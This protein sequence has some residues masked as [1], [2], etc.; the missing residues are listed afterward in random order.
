MSVDTL[1]PALARLGLEAPEALLRPTAPGV[2]GAAILQALQAAMLAQLTP[3]AAVSTAQRQQVLLAAGR[4]LLA[5]PE[6]LRSALHL[7][8]QA[9]RD[10]ALT[11]PFVNLRI[12]ALE[13][14]KDRGGL[15]RT[16]NR[17]IAA[18]ALPEPVAQLVA[19]AAERHDIRQLLALPGALHATGWGPWVDDLPAQLDALAQ[20]VPSPAVSEAAIEH[21]FR[22]SRAGTRSY[23]DYRARLLHGVNLGRYLFYLRN[24]TS[25]LGAAQEGAQSAPEDQR[26]MRRWHSEI[27]ALVRLPDASLLQQAEAQGRTLLVLGSH[28][29]A[30]ALLGRSME[31]CSLP[32]SS[33]TQNVSADREGSFNISTLAPDATLRFA[34][35]IKMARRSPRLVFMFPDGAVGDTAVVE[36]QGRKLHIGRG[37]ASLAWFTRALPF[38]TR[39]VIEDGAIVLRL[40]PGPAVEEGE[41]MERYEKRLNA[42]YADCLREILAGPPENIGELVNKFNPPK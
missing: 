16:L 24:R 28:G 29:G 33:I 18:R 35:L 3:G 13:R 25:A 12:V 15:I 27:G 10:S 42:F 5:R 26:I 17:I 7:A 23:D 41:E 2:D 37:G 4:R 22:H 34:K 14:L 39:T 6:T 32:R 1:P 40:V 19:G 9:G 31:N 38:F 21:L 20:V 30:N 36:V 8:E 11:A